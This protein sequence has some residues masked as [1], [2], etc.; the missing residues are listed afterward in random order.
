MGGAAADSFALTAQKAQ[1]AQ[2][3]LQIAF[4]N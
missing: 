3:N 1:K 2:T 4:A